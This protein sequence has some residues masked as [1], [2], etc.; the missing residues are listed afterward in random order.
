MPFSSMSASIL[1]RRG[2][3]ALVLGSPGDHRIISAVTQVIS[4]WVDVGQGIEA[5]VAAPRIHTIRNEEVMLERPPGNVEGLL[6]LERRGYS[7]YQPLGSLFAG[8]YNPY[9]GGVHAVA[10][11]D[12]HWRGAADPRR[13]GESAYARGS[14]QEV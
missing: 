4:H 8:D 7:V 14:R 2:G 12:G 3:P 13:D 1:S 11:E 10:Q 5:A 6:K 9:F